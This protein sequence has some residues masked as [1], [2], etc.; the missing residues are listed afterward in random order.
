MSDRF[1]RRCG[2]AFKRDKTMTV[3]GVHLGLSFNPPRWEHRAVRLLE[4]WVEGNVTGHDDWEK[5]NV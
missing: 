4:L 3:W 5:H 2:L 1:E